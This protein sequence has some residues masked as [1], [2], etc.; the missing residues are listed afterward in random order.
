MPNDLANLLGD[1]DA[2]NGISRVRPVTSGITVAREGEAVIV[3]IG[4][5]EPIR[6][7]YRTAMEEGQAMLMR[8]RVQPRV[9]LQ[10]GTMR[11]P[12]WFAARDAIRIGQWLI[13]RAAEAKFLA[14]DTK[15]I[16]VERR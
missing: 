10:I 7:R 4:N 14:S 3:Q 9:P 5:V 6:L 8:A 16:L 15:R 11:H 12:I 2:A 1:G 13:S